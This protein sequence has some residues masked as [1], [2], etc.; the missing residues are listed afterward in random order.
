MRTT[1]HLRVPYYVKENFHLE[2]QGSMRRLE[3]SVEE[4]YMNN[5]RNSCY[6]EKNYS[7]LFSFLNIVLITHKI[8]SLQFLKCVLARLI[9]YQN[10]KFHFLSGNKITETLCSFCIVVC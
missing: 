2:Y 7:E 4:E 8:L 10:E 3:A 9:K 1:M 6:R 5:L